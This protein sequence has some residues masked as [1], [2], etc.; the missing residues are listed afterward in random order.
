M[1]DLKTDEKAPR[2]DLSNSIGKEVT[3]FLREPAKFKPLKLDHGA[4]GCVGRLV[5]SD[6][7]GL[8]F[9]PQAAKD[10]ALKNSASGGVPHVFLSWDDVLSLVRY[11]PTE[12]YLSKKE[13][14]GLR[15]S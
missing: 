13:Y 1:S 6:R 12:D 8:W 9:E 5:G 3:L 7:V 2:S 11:Q 4:D 15:P 10:A 14:R